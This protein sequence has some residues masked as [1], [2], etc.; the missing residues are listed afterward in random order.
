MNEEYRQALEDLEVKRTLY[1]HANKNYEAVA[2]HE[3]KA[4]EER[5]IAIIKEMKQQKLNGSE[6]KKENTNRCNLIEKLKQLIRGGFK[7]RHAQ[8]A[9][10][11]VAEQKHWVQCP[12]IS[13]PI[14]MSH[15]FRECQ[16]R[17]DGHCTYRRKKPCSA[18][19]TA[20]NSEFDLC[21]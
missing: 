5:V 14:C 10:K 19:N 4:A 15:C 16:Y 7:C 6:G 2:Y 20:R 18:T 21:H 1:A 13:K 17:K 12:R 8:Y 3:M 11:T 9:K